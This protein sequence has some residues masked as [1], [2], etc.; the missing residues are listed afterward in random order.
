MSSS[1][2]YG[3]LAVRGLALGFLIALFVHASAA[4]Q[5][6]PGPLSKAHSRLAGVT[7]CLD[8]HKIGQAAPE[9]RCMGCHDEIRQRAAAQRGFH[10]AVFRKNELV[11][12][13]CVSCH[14]EHNGESFSLIHWDGP[15]EKFDHRFTGYW[16]EGRH[17]QI[18]CRQCHQPA[19]IPAA[20]ARTISTSL[21]R[22][23]LGLTRDCLNCHKDEHRGQLSRDCR[24]C[25]DFTSWKNT[26]L[27]SHQW[28]DF[29]LDGGHEKIACEKCHQRTSDAAGQNVQFKG[30][31]HEDCTPCHRDPHR[32]AFESSCKSCHNVT[33]WKSTRAA[34]SFDHDKAKFPLRGKHTGLACGSCHKGTDFKQPVVH[35]LCGDCHRKDPHG[36]QFATATGT[37]DC[38]KCHTAD[39]FKSSSFDVAKHASTAFPL[40]GK[41][42]LVTC[43]RCH[44]PH[45]AETR[46]RI[47]GQ[48]CANCHTDAHQGQFAQDRRNACEECHSVAGFLPTIFLLAKHGSTRFPLHGAHAAVA[49]DDCHAGEHALD[50]AQKAGSSAGTSR[51]SRARFRF[52]YLT[53]TACH[54]DLHKGRFAKRMAAA[55]VDGQSLSCAACHSTK[56]WQDIPGFDHSSTS[57]V[58]D[59]AHKGAS[60]AACHL[61]GRKG[62]QLKDAVFADTPRQCSGCHEDAHN[63]QFADQKRPGDC[64]ACHNAFWWRPS[65]F[66]HATHSTFKL[67]GAHAQVPCALCHDRTREVDGRTV[68][69]YRPTPRRCS[70]C[71]GATT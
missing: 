33:G 55:G 47:D 59:G 68:R 8:C 43:A 15:V 21:E 4:G 26:T 64:S 57:F 51:V 66:D 11:D 34:S 53:C 30:I 28:A 3:R 18:A 10:G 36:G 56:A 65:L 9:F 16:L 19:R 46:Y 67:D 5:I 63:G 32:A 35:E 69:I 17:A 2:V 1:P 24:K 70:D 54:E 31:R 52:S 45:G 40:T 25:H 42:E 62:S 60:C 58:L 37:A 14:S 13:V 6:S 27:F 48:R 29:P 12:R 23:Y 49:C 50:T 7:H 38:S 71:H 61:P 39:G 22:T 41:H 44:A 20:E